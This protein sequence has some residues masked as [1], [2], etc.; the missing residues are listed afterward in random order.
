MK[1]FF[2]DLYA[3]IKADA[4]NAVALVSTALGSLMAHIDELA[5]ALG[6]PSLNQQIH[7][8]ITDAKWFG[9]WMLFVGILT[10]VARFK[11]LVQSPK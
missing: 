11:S 7:T 10:T 2:S 3:K 1:K 8:V 6:D 5:T 9:H 4:L